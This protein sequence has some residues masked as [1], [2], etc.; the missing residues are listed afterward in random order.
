MNDFSG[1]PV[2]DGRLWLPDNIPATGFER[3]TLLTHL[4]LSYLGL[5]GPIPD[6]IGKLV[7]LLSLDLSSSIVSDGYDVPQMYQTTPTLTILILC[8]C[9]TLIP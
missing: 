4:N 9:S 7:N 5:R 1:D 6:G 8:G 2:D 3:F